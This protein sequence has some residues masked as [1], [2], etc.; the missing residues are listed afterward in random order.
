MLPNFLQ[1]RYKA[2]TFKELAHRV[3]V[4]ISNNLNETNEFYDLIYNKRFIPAG[5]TLLVGID[6]I[7]PNCAILPSINENNFK[8][9]SDRAKV[10]WNDRI[11]I[12]FDLSESSNPIK[13]LE[14]LSMLNANIKLGHRPQRGNM[15]V[16]NSSH[17]MI[18]EFIEI[19]S[20]NKNLYNF[21]ISVGINESKDI[22]LYPNDDLLDL[23]SQNAW[24]NGDPG[25][26]FLDRIQLKESEHLGKIKTLV[27]CGEQGMYDNEVCTLGSMNLNSSDFWINNNLNEKMFIDSIRLAVR[28]LDNVV[29]KMQINDELLVEQLYNTRRIGLGVM[30]YAD[31][32]NRLNIKYG[33]KQSLQLIDYIGNLYQQTAHE[34]STEL[35]VEKGIYPVFKNEGIK[36]RH[37]TI[38]CIAPTGG[39]SLLTS[40][41]GFGIEPFFHEANNLTLEDHIITQSTWQKYVDNCISKT[42][43]LPY[44][45]TPSDIKNVWIQARNHNLKS[46]TVYRDKCMTSQ[47]IKTDCISGKC[48]I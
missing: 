40:N 31:I 8:E 19:K 24:K 27:P 28:F 33:S 4:N 2:R 13:I 37:I 18:K 47:P 15:A 17:P 16:L 35:A 14:D 1:L 11:G 46:V 48:D 20:N 6:P 7:R 45:S 44:K 29:D 9:L 21:N 41:K 30:G 12:G 42:I 3:S 38:T 34:T 36:R 5:N 43:N 10:L 32:L 26:V 22:N 39:I 25:L 23:M